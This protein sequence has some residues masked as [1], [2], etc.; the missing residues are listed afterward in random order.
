M[1]TI[2][3]ISVAIFLA[4]AVVVFF[5]AAVRANKGL[6]A[7]ANQPSSLPV[8]LVVDVEAPEIVCDAAWTAAEWWSREL[9]GQVFDEIAG[10][11]TVT[12]L[13]PAAPAGDD[14]MARATMTFADDHKKMTAAF[15]HIADT[16]TFD[17]RV[18]TRALAHELGHVLGLDHD[19]VRASVMF[20]QTA[21]GADF[22]LLAADRQL[23]RARYSL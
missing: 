16:A 5:L 3:L 7:V 13:K 20:P 12:V 14:Y 18:L 2:A 10:E 23:L 15:I 9:G 21:G 1:I 17:R 6:M 19:Q 4:F 8:A 22:V 11:I